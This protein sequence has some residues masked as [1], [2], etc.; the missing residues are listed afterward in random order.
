[1]K[2]ECIDVHCQDI[3]ASHID[4]GEMGYQEIC[5][6][7]E[8]VERQQ[9][10]PSVPCTSIHER[11]CIYLLVLHCQSHLI[12]IRGSRVYVSYQDTQED[13][14]VRGSGICKVE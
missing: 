6:A 1:M 3:E 2:S 7:K 12:A 13:H 5:S 10:C 14:F 4:R 8:R 9:V 11:I